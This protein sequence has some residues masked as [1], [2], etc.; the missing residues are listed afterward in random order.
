MN[1]YLLFNIGMSLFSLV[2]IQTWM[3]IFGE[4]KR[5]NKAVSIIFSVLFVS[6]QLWI[7]I[8]EASNTLLVSL[9]TFSFFVIII[10]SYHP[11]NLLTILFRVGII[12][13]VWVL[14]EVVVSVILVEMGVLNDSFG[15]IL[16]SVVSKITNFLLAQ[17]VKRKQLTK[18]KFMI[19]FRNW[20]RL[21]VVPIISILIIDAVYRITIRS[22]DSFVLI[23]ITLSLLLLNYF[24]FSLYDE[25]EKQMETEEKNM[26]YEQQLLLCS[27]QAEEREAAYQETRA[28]HHDLKNYL[29]DLQ[30][31]LKEGRQDELA[32]RINSLL[33]KNQ[34]YRNEISHTGNTVIDALI[35]NKYSVAIAQGLDIRCEIEPLGNLSF[36]DVDLCIILGNL[37]DNALE[38]VQKM[39][40][41]KGYIEVSVKKVKG[42]LSLKVANSFD[43][44]V[45][46]DK[47]GKFLTRKDDSKSHGIGLES[48][49]RTVEKYNGEMLLSEENNRFTADILLYSS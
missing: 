28:V 3:D 22:S 35:N 47:K 21:F 31:C 45:K 48:V 26:I 20:L 33:E 15:F 49:K 24:T 16:G 25:L 6:F 39:G 5:K 37:L 9:G 8:S 23:T 46:K 7:H 42:A 36:E 18:N 41:S 12:Y 14:L 44:Y 32:D 27:R 4:I 40:S 11:C 17:L 34:I 19:S 1:E 43:G 29:L 30:I 38:A 13:V 2:I 10:W